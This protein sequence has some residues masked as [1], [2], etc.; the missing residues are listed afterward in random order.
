M[1]KKQETQEARKER[2]MPNNIPKYVRVYDNGG[3]GCGG[4]FDRYTVVFSGNYRRRLPTGEFDC[5]CLYVGMSANPFHPQGFGQHGE[6]PYPI[7]AKDGWAPAIGRKC[8]LGIRINFSDLP[9][10]CQ[11]LVRDDYNDIWFW[12]NN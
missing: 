1:N 3:T 6:N 4:T 9:P 5:D 10:D 8:H 12:E 7:D 11:K 2:L